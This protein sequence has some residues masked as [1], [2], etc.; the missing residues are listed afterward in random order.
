MCVP[1]PRPQNC[2]FPIS[3][4][5]SGDLGPR[6]RSQ[7]LVKTFIFRF[8]YL[9]G[10]TVL[11]TVSQHHCF[12][13][14][15]SLPS[16]SISKHNVVFTASPS[17]RSLLFNCASASPAQA[18][19]RV[20]AASA[21]AKP[22]NRM[23]AFFKPCLGEDWQCGQILNPYLI[24]S[25]HWFEGK[26][27]KIN[28]IRHQQFLSLTQISTQLRDFLIRHKVPRSHGVPWF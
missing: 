1:N 4:S 13:L 3:Q 24:D 19:F 16:I 8:N 17:R 14:P 7:C 22:A 6:V 26:S 11:P 5:A 2:C 15:P 12:L 21:M 9:K 28:P 25:I 23:K 20:T 18:Q 27:W 10:C